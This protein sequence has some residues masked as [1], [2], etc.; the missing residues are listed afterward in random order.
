MSSKHR[1]LIV[2]DEPLNVKLFAAMLSSDDRE[3]INA[4][5][6]EQ[7]LEKVDDASPDLILLDVMMPG[8][9]GFEVTRR[10]K[11]RFE[12]RDIPIILITAIDNADFKA[13]G[14]E[15]GADEFLNKPIKA[16]ELKS[17]VKSLLHTKEY[18]DKLKL[19]I[20]SETK[21]DPNYEEKLIL[22]ENDRLPVLLVLEEQKDAKSIEMFLHGQPYQVIVGNKAKDAMNLTS[23]RRVDLILLD[24]KLQGENFFEICRY[25]KEQEQTANIQVLVLSDSDVLEN[26]HSKFVLWSDDFLIKPVNVFEL[27]TRVKALLK[28]KTFLDRLYAGPAGSVR[29]AITDSITGLANQSYFNFFLDH[30]IKRSLRDGRPVALLM[31]EFNETKHNLNCAGHPAGE[32]SLKDL[33]ILIKENIRSID[34]GARCKEKQFAIVLTNTDGNGARMVAE[35]LKSLIQTQLSKNSENISAES[36]PLNIGIAVYPSNADSI[37]Q[38]INQAEKGL[39]ESKTQKTHSDFEKLKPLPVLI[40]NSFTFN[41]Q[42]PFDCA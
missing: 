26:Q 15:A 8:I 22:G 7:A 10:L 36:S 31:M 16:V 4:Y 24:A 40:C 6:G 9:D 38:L 33:G 39:C 25:L 37:K 11:G 29:A 12:T 23:Q 20:Q 41:N 27:R 2:D 3:I 30:E 18:Q 5:N 14:H 17:R 32:E 13:I 28:K 42:L 1:I 21:K 34:L 19:Q 35:R